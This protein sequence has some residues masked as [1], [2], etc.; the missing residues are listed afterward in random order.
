M[1][2]FFAMVSAACFGLQ[3]ASARRGAL[4]GTAVQGLVT[5]MVAGTLLFLGCATVFGE[6]G[7]LPRMSWAEVGFLSAAG[8]AHFVWG[9]YWNIRALG[10]IGANLAGPVQQYQL[11]LSLS[12]AIIFLGESLTPMKILG[13][14]MV[15][16]A[17]AFI[18]ERRSTARRTAAKAAKAVGADVVTA[19]A[20]IDD[21]DAKPAFKPRLLEGYTCS[22]LSGLGFGSS[23]VLAKAGLGSTHAG[24]AGGFI[25]YCCAT[26]CVGLILLL[27]GKLAEVRAM[28]GETRK[29]F[30]MS[31]MAVSFSQMFRYLALSLA[32][33]TVVQ[34]IQSTSLIWRM[35]FGYF[36]NREHEQFDRYV[37]IGLCLSF[38]GAFALAMSDNLILS[39]FDAPAWLIEW[40]KWTW[41]NR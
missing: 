7:A 17:P 20:A 2:I 28:R 14:L 34:P 36:I 4:S 23:S 38:T 3:N 5:S 26:T 13:I 39:Y 37:L 8:F 19:E 24:F 25:S 12:L 33:V 35:V 9:R 1:G 10:A 41:P 29:W 11:L 27:P 22:V 18:L 30:F 6:L 31:G 16:S 21:A 15:I 40:S 32:P